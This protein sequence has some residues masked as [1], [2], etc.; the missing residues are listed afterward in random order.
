MPATVAST[1]ADDLKRFS[2]VIACPHVDLLQAGKA[3]VPLMA[4]GALDGHLRFRSIGDK[5]VEHGARHESALLSALGHAGAS[6]HACRSIEIAHCARL[7]RTS[8]APAITQR[9]KPKVANCAKSRAARAKI[10]QRPSRCMGRSAKIAPRFRGASFS[11]THRFTFLRLASYGITQCASCVR[12]RGWCRRSR[13]RRTNRRDR[14]VAFGPVR[15]VRGRRRGRHR[16]RLARSR[17]VEPQAPPVD[18]AS[19]RHALGHRLDR[20]AGARVARGHPS[21]ASAVAAPLFGFACGGLMHL[22]A[23][24]PN[25]LGVPWIWRRHSL[26]LWKS[27]RCDL[28]VVAAAWAAHCGSRSHVLACTAARALARLAQSRLIAIRRNSARDRRADIH[29][30]FRSLKVR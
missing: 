27:G 28:I 26:N 21:S 8:A 20:A 15:R 23:D 1:T 7:P 4:A 12:L 5:R 13:P 16:A 14:P 29:A 9:T 19:H 17:M 11:R 22:L 6:E 30:T 25:P 18:H 10:C 24:W 2:V 3:P